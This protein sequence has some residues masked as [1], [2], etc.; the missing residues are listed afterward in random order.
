VGTLNPNQDKEH[1]KI[2]SERLKRRGLEPCTD[3]EWEIHG[4]HPDMNY[5]IYVGYADLRNKN[6]KCRCFG[7]NLS[8]GEC[9][10]HANFYCVAIYPRAVY[11]IEDPE[12]WWDTKPENRI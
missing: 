8:V 5:Q 11:E 12:K 4:P 9:V 7:C 10:K 1:F 2:I 6:Q 3:E